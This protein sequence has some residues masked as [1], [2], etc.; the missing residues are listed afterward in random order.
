MQRYHRHEVVEGERASVRAVDDASV[1]CDL[2]LGGHE[3]ETTDRLRNEESIISKHF[4]D[5]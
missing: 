4:T 5:V 3:A 1:L 2:S